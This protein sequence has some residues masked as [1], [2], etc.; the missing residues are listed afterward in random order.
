M[1]A[2]HLVNEVIEFN[3][4]NEVNEVKEVNEKIRLAV[5]FVPRLAVNRNCVLAVAVTAKTPR[6]CKARGTTSR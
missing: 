5:N 2:E 6:A 1:H 3:K 4:V